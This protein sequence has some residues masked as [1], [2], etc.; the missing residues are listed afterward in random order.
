MS[1]A[2]RLFW[3]AAARSAVR[4]RSGGRLARAVE[5]FPGLG[6][7]SNSEDCVVSDP[8]G[9]HTLV[10]DRNR[11]D[12]REQLAEVEASALDG[13]DKNRKRIK[14]HTR[15]S[16]RS[17]KG[18][19]VVGVTVLAEDGSP[20]NDKGAFEALRSHWEPVFNN[21][22]GDRRAFRCFSKFVQKCPEGVEPLG[23]EEFRDICGVARRSAPGPDGIGHMAWRAGGEIV[24]DVV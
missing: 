13:G 10:C 22:V 7:F 2:S 18:R 12:L 6:D 9:L 11:E 19:F 4:A 3:I 21:V 8:S 20:T 5:R 15:L 17:L 16:S 14:I 1:P 24:A 23:R